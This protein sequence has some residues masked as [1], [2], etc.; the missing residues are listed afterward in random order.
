MRYLVALVEAN[1]HSSVALPVR[2]Q[3]DSE[4]YLRQLVPNARLT[5]RFV[6]GVGSGG[7]GM[8]SNIRDQPLQA[9]FRMGSVVDLAVTSRWGLRTQAVLEVRDSAGTVHAVPFEIDS[10]AV[11]KPGAQA[12]MTEARALLG[13]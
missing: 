13:L 1:N 12:R 11:P 9:S 6:I 4:F 7:L 10:V 3:S 8:L 5:A 2:S